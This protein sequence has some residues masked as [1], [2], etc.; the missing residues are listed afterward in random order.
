MHVCL[1]AHVCNVFCFFECVCVCV[2]VCVCLWFSGGSFLGWWLFVFCLFICCICIQMKR[3]FLCDLHSLMSVGFLMYL[4]MND[5]LPGCLF[6]VV[7][8]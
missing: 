5:I 3:Q 8:I 2:C 4:F 1:S 7:I 6:A